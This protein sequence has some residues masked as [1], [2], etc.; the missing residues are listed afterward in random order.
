MRPSTL[1]TLTGDR[2]ERGREGMRR[3]LGHSGRVW[4]EVALTRVIRHARSL[5]A[6]QRAHPH[7][8]E[9]Y[10]KRL[11][12]RMGLFSFR[13]CES[14]HLAERSLGHP[15]RRRGCLTPGSLPASPRQT[16][17]RTHSAWGTRLEDSAS[18]RENKTGKIK[19][20]SSSLFRFDRLRLGSSSSSLV[21]WSLVAVLPLVSRIL[22]SFYLHEVSLSAVPI[23]GAPRAN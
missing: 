21:V 10:L 13:R 20:D 5:A 16:T 4:R 7:H 12:A 8:R 15:R 18:S 22:L 3:E 1:T 23:V 2:D 11:R 14:R 9:T 6:T 17:R 19:R